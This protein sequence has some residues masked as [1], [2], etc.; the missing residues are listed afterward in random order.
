MMDAAKGQGLVVL[1]C[2]AKRMDDLIG[3]GGAELDI[4]A[5]APSR[6]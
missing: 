3:S 1:P 5:I 2:I 4:T 6:D